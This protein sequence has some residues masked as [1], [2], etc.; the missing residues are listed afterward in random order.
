M[1]KLT[2]GPE[3]QALYCDVSAND[4]RPFVPA[5]FRRQVF[6]VFHNLNHPSGKITAQIIEQRYVWP[7]MRRDIRNWAKTCIQYQRAK[8]GRHVHMQTE[9]FSQPDA[10]FDHVHIDIIGPLTPCE[11]YTHCLTMIDRFSRWPEAIPIKNHQADT[12]AKAFYTYWIARFGSPKVVTTNQGSEF[13]SKL[14]AASIKLVGGK[15][16][17]TT[18]HHPAS[19]GLIERWHRTLKSAIKCHGQRWIDILPT[20][21]L[22]LRTCYKKDLEAS[23]AEY[24]YGTL[25]RILGEFFT[26]EDLPIDQNIF[27][28][29]FRIHMRTLKPAPVTHHGKR[30]IFCYK[31]L[32]SCTHVF[33]RQE[34]TK[35]ESLDNPYAGPYRVIERIND[36]VFTVDA[37][38]KP[39]NVAIERLKPAHLLSTEVFEA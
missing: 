1:Q 22:G 35:K 21:L 11:G 8:I 5:K 6:D 18:A 29:D 28:E 39:T 33:I 3:H 23:P 15:R 34:N 13:E 10:R 12:I 30:K 9:K 19:N 27:L 14:F 26:H 32:Y 17:Y 24:L 16:I 36:R 2:F 31:E 20:V 38:G 7:S 4:I 37:N 25:L